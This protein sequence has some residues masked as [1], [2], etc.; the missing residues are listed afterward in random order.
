M[1]ALF[2]PAKN[3][4]DRLRYP[5]KISFLTLLLLIPTGALS[6][7][8]VTSKIEDVQVIENE[9]VGLTY[10]KSLRGPIEHIQQHRSLTTAFLGGATEYRSRILSTQKVVDEKLAELREIDQQL[11]GQFSVLDD[12]VLL[13]QDWNSVKSNALNMSESEA[14]K[15]HSALISEMLALTR[16]VADASGITQDTTLDGQRI[17]TA[18]VSGIPNLLENM[19][20]ASAVGSSVATKGAFPSSEDKIRL[21]VLSANIGLYFKSAESSLQSAFN[22][23]AGISKQLITATYSNATAIESI[24]TLLNDEL[25]NANVI[26]VEADTVL[27]TTARAISGGYI[28]YDSLMLTLDGLLAERILS[29]RTAMIVS[30]S[31]VAI[32]FFL[33]AYFLVGFYLSLMQSIQQISDA[34]QRL[35]GGDLDVE[36]VLDSRDEMNQ[37][38]TGFN[39]MVNEFA[40][41]LTQISNTVSKLEI[42]SDGLSNACLQTNRSLDI[43]IDHTEEVASAMTEMSSAVHE[44]NSSIAATAATIEEANAGALGGNDKVETTIEAIHTLVEQMKE[45]SSAVEQLEHDCKD[46]SS[47]LEVIVSVADETN[48]LSLN[49][50]IEAAH[51]AEHGRGFAVVADQVRTLAHRTQDS[52]VE[53]RQV[54]EKLLKGSK[55]AVEVMNN[56]Q[57]VADTV[58]AR[59][60]ESGLSISAMS[61]SIGKINEMSISIAGAAEEQSTTVEHINNSIINISDMTKDNTGNAERL[62]M[63]SEELKGMASELKNTVARFRV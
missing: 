51:A 19:G 53:I 47:V 52:A 18:L 34:S 14:I 57:E 10:I 61:A 6:F 28:L 48:L 43:Q 20:E 23:N 59:A 25:L 8:F 13:I 41:L 21:S 55:R 5:T 56:S 9:R 40:Q 1:K 60:Q 33:F 15:A 29:G 22:A 45:G 24:Q 32:L 62:S 4:M 27:S 30:T 17:G 54:I 2:K 58:V 3:V 37:I 31:I 63:E 46:I 16:K 11:G 36:I 42:S 26:T 39:M 49:A 35:T 12:V 7:D 50:A 38:A 44:V